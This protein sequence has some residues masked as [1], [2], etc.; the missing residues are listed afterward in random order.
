MW[1]RVSISIRGGVVAMAGVSGDVCRVSLKYTVGSVVLRNIWFYRLDDPPTA[2]YLT[3]LLTE[4]Q[5]A[6]LTPL[7]AA[8]IN[9]FT[10]TEIIA[11]NIFS[12]D[13]VI[14][15]T[16]TPAAGTRAP[17]GDTLAA[18]LAEMFVLERQNGRVR[19]GRK[20]IP[21]SL[22]SD[23]VGSF[24]VAGTNTLVQAIA[25]ASAATLNPGGVDTFVPCI[26]GRIPYTTSS[27][28]TAY[29]L[30]NTQGE[31]GDNYSLVSSARAIN[32]VTTMNS[33]KF[34]RGE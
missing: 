25:T 9:T 19:N 6:V 12:G 2:G 8:L 1:E 7:A 26:V 20:F 18:F 17:S 28:R 29:R 23:I 15:V 21:L 16:P 14:D 31:M 11:S 4:F 34:W 3:G 33:R 13:E 24:V 10:F 30:P 5:T 27:G 32:R 22:E